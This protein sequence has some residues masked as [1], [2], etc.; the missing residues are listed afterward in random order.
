MA[1]MLLIHTNNS[2]EGL[3]LPKKQKPYGWN[4]GNP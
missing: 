2:Y 1:A 3:S 4:Q